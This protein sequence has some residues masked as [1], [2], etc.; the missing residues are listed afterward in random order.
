[1]GQTAR[2]LGCTARSLTELCKPEIGLEFGARRLKK[3]FDRKY[4]IARDAL[5]DYNGSGEAAYPDLVLGRMK[6][7]GDEE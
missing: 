7:Y 4:G 2:E 6:N 1:M 3:A 5:L